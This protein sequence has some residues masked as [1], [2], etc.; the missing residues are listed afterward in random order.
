MS[1]T[2]APTMSIVTPCHGKPLLITTRS[3]GRAYMTYDVPDEIL[4]SEPGCYNTWDATG[5]TN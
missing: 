5:L 3:E 1:E 2:T 4:C